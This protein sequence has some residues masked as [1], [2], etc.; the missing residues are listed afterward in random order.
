[1]PIDRQV[2]KKDMVYIHNGKLLSHQKERNNAIC[3]NIG[4]SRDFH[5]KPSKSERER[6]ILPYD[7]TYMWNLKY[8]T[9][10]HIYETKTDSPKTDLSL[11]RGWGQ[12]REGLGVWD[13][14]KQ[15]SI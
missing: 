10:Q 5:T 4:G 11:P 3:S 1:M 8:S 6:Q 2:D 14:Q 9:N 7:I 12:K 13:Q 15:T